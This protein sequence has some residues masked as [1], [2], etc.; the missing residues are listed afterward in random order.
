M[1]LSDANAQYVKKVDICGGF[2]RHIGTISNCQFPS[3]Y[4]NQV[5]YWSDEERWPRVDSSQYLFEMN[6]TQ[7]QVSDYII[8]D[9]ID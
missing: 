8:A 2:S 7:L 4:F 5:N 3:E 6:G 9:D 1:I